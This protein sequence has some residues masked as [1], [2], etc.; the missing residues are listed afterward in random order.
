MFAD[1]AV[2][3]WA[4]AALGAM[5]ATIGS[6]VLAQEAPGADID[7]M[8]DASSSVDGAIGLARR[9]AG[10]GDLTG[11]A[12]TL[13]RILLDRSGQRA[14]AARIYYIAILCRLDDHERANV[15][16]AKLGGLKVADSGWSEARQACG[17]ITLPV[18]GAQPDRYLTGQIAAGI[19]YDSDA[20]GALS[21]QFDFGL[22]AIRDD[23]FAF[24]G[25]IALDGRTPT[26]G[27][28]V[29]GGVAAQTKDSI[30]GPSL[31]YQ[32]GSARLG[33]GQRAGDLDLSIGVVGR[34]ARIGGADFFGEVGG[35]AEIALPRA[36]SRVA[37][38]GE[39]VRQ[40]YANALPFFSRNG[41]RY[42]LALDLQGQP[43]I[44]RS[45]VIGAAFEH[46]TADTS[47]LGY[48]GGRVYAAAKL[49]IGSDGVYTALSA[50]IRHFAYRADFLGRHQIETRYFS[51]AAIGVPIGD[52]G[53]DLEAAVSYTRRDYNRSSL[54]FD[55]D[56]VGGELRLVYTF[57]G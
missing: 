6:P 25:S 36:D 9:Q 39:M 35:Q 48:T 10:E 21:T 55:Y 3:R 28:Y 30:S 38:R 41:T 56:D 46:K 24:I 8:I 15:E 57:G 26:G 44:D 27:G 7:A 40:R 31:D 33:Y 34:Y 50:T 47:F 5:A 29:Y 20:F 49:P 37:L 12:A 22:P 43:A 52:S 11:A 16:I 45:Y 14:A 42:D 32:I 19:G 1:I 18:A 23:G 13:E 54:L 17:T 53:F 4:I 2:R 51:R